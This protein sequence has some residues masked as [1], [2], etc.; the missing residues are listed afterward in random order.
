MPNE[1]ARLRDLIAHHDFAIDAEII[2]DVAANYVP[3]LLEAA[4]RLRDQYDDG[5]ESA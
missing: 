2:W 1:P 3:P 5:N 4:R